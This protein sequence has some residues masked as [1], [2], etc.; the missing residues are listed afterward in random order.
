MLLYPN[1]DE[2]HKKALNLIKNNYDYAYIVHDKDVNS[3]T[4][5]IKKSHIHCVV[6]FNNAKWNTS[7]AEEIG[8]L[9]NY[10]QPIKNYEKCL[11]YLIHYNDDSKYQYSLDDVKGSLK[12]KLE[13]FILNDDKDENEKTI[14]LLDFIDNNNCYITTTSFMRYCASIGMYDVARRSQTF[15]LQALKEHNLLYSSDR[16]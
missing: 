13:R 3:D 7:F 5:E 8:L 12:K 11:E 10:I 4:G 9:V 14:D 16:T 2:S 1:E 6:S 15:Y